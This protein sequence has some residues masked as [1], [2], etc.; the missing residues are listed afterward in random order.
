MTDSPFPLR[1]STGNLWSDAQPKRT[2][3]PVVRHVS[4][5]D[6]DAAPS[7]GEPWLMAAI[8]VMFV[9]LGLAFYGWAA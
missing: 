8:V 7:T 2:L 6:Y 5:A 3:A 9:V 4:A 1:D